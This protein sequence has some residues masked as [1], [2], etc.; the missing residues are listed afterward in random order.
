MTRAPSPITVLWPV[1]FS[2]FGSLLIAKFIG[3]G[4]GLT[5]GTKLS[6]SLH[7]CSVVNSMIHNSD[8]I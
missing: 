4:S 1:S 5:Y 7:S 2:M 6:I 8:I 3:T